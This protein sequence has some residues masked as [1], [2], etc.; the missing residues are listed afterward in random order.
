MAARRAAGRAPDR[1]GPEPE[2]AAEPRAW[3]TRSS[4]GSAPTP[5]ADACPAGHLPRSSRVRVADG[6]VG[7]LLPSRSG[8]ITTARLP[9]APFALAICNDNFYVD[10]G[11]STGDDRRGGI[12]RS[13]LFV[14]G[15]EKDYPLGLA[16]SVIS[17]LFAHTTHARSDFSQR[18]RWL[19][20]MRWR[21]WIRCVDMAR[22]SRSRAGRSAD[23]SMRLWCFMPLLTARITSG[24]DGY[25]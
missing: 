13:A 21:A 18:R 5:A 4:G 7:G 17:R 10:C 15:A 14:G 3:S 12:R 11:R 22:R 16:F 2:E 23:V 19:S 1:P 20:A 24:K 8:R 6:G 9:I 25:R